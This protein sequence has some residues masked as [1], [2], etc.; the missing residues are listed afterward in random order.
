LPVR[1]ALLDLPQMMSE[2]VKDILDQAMDVAV[3]K[4]SEREDADVVILATDGDDLPAAGRI[5]LARRATAR[6]IAINGQGR[7][8]YLYELR[9]HRTPLGEVSADSLLAAIRSPVA[10]WA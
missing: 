3:V 8:A 4:A 5:Q 2:I 6:V 9:P 7:S 10:D 1:V